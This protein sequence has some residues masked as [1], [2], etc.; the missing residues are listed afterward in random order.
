M[1]ES[2]EK[3]TKKKKLSVAV[4]IDLDEL[5]TNVTAELK[6]K[7]PSLQFNTTAICVDALYRA[8]KKAKSELEKMEKPQQKT[9]PKPEVVVEPPTQ[10]QSQQSP[11]DIVT[12]RKGYFS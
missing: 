12:Q 2:I 6:V 4:P 3:K 1:F 5:I 8:V 9:E 10:P 7:A 11:D